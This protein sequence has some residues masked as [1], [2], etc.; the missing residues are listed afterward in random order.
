MGLGQGVVG[1][2]GVEAGVV[3]RHVVDDESLLVRDVEPASI[4]HQRPG[5]PVRRTDTRRAQ[6]MTLLTA[7]KDRW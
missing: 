4:L 1:D 5:N 2:A 6:S 3:L 7:A